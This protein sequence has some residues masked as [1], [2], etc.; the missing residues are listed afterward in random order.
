M[1]LISCLLKERRFNIFRP[2]KTPS[3]S[4]YQCLLLYYYSSSAIFSLFFSLM[5]SLFPCQSDWTSTDISRIL[6][7]LLW[8]SELPPRDCIPQHINFIQH[9]SFLIKPRYFFLIVQVISGTHH[10]SGYLLSFLDLKWSLLGNNCQDYAF[11]YECWLI[12]SQITQHLHVATCP[13]T[14]SDMIGNSFTNCI[15]H[16]FAHLTTS[17]SFSSIPVPVLSLQ[18]SIFF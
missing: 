4:F 12:V 1:P 11:I 15:P 7:K 14:L 16:G 10:F 13:P 9:S 17:T 3:S 5:I 2:C 6:L 18:L 8:N